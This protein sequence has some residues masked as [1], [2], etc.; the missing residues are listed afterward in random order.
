MRC[1]QWDTLS[2]NDGS[3]CGY[4]MSFLDDCWGVLLWQS[5]KLAVEL[6]LYNINLG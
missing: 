6:K 3:L 4:Q 1:R 5:Y 2:C